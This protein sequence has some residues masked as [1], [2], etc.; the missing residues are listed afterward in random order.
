MVVPAPP[1]DARPAAGTPDGGATAAAVAPGRA[2]FAA[3]LAG[4]VRR[5]GRLAAA[6]GLLALVAAGLGLA[7]YEVWA[8]YHFRAARDALEHYH[9]PQAVRHLKVC[10]RVWPNDPDV[11]LLAARAARRARVYGDAERCLEKYQQL[12]GTDEAGSLEQLLLS[13]QRDPD[14]KAD[15][16]QRYVEKER[17]EAPLI[18][19]AV[20]RGYL[21]HYRVAETRGCLGRWLE[22]QPENPQALCLQGQFR[23]E[24]ERN[25]H[26]A[27]DS[28]RRAVQSDPDH[29]EARA[30][31]AFALLELKS[32]PAALE[33]LDYLRRVQPDNTYLLVG[34]AECQ[35]GLGE[36]AEAM[37]LADRVLAEQPDYAP[38]LALRGRLALEAGDPVAAER[39]LRDAVARNPNDAQARYNLVLCLHRNGAEAEAQR[40]QQESNQRDRDTKRFQ[41]IVTHDLPA[42]P[43]DPALHCEL[44][45]LMLRLGRPEEGRQ[46]LLSALRLDAGYA[47]ARQALEE[48]ARAGAGEPPPPP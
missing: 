27:A 42:R 20:T 8:N 41:E 31:L 1:G 9:N 46:W 14:A 21:E 4:L 18:L 25:L 38:A 35:D 23:L 2:R 28:Y 22:A 32:Y 10:L 16:C 30:G 24:Y 33:Q 11:L 12:R 34:V 5:G 37:R 45:Q 3:R 6:L 29:E 43:R 47:P 48:R 26:G 19:E 13:A 17:P 15:V 44:G 39:W 40:Q 36:Q 7:G